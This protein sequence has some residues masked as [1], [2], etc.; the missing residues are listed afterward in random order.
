MSDRLSTH[1]AR[2]MAGLFV[3]AVAILSA[4]SER[5]ERSPGPEGSM[6]S[7]YS[8][9]NGGASKGD[10]R[11]ADSGSV[12][13]AEGTMGDDTTAD[14]EVL[15]DSRRF[16]CAAPVSCS[17]G[18]RG[19]PCLLSS[20][21]LPSDEPSETSEWEL[22]WTDPISEIPIAL[23]FEV[24]LV[25]A[26]SPEARA[27]LDLLVEVRGIVDVPLDVHVELEEIPS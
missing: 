15:C 8:V 24:D 20:T 25:L 6:G 3:L 9:A 27:E 4:C 22:A 2:E 10:T 16:D 5:S 18:P 14:A 1:L 26:G 11:T 19:V 12:D 17:R 21:S 13:V 23:E 7:T